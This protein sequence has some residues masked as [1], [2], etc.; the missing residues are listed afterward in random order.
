M[1]EYDDGFQRVRLEVDGLRA[2]IVTF[3]R[4]RGAITERLERLFASEITASTVARV[5]DDELAK[6]V[7]SCVA[8]VV[9]EAMWRQKPKMKDAVRGALVEMLS[10]P[11][12]RTDE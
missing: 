6:L 1:V 2:S 5:I 9:H 11:P 7:S 12:E 4:E 8:E 10:A 3:L